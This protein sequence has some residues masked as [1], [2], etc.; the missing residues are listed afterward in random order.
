M[1]HDDF[2]GFCLSRHDPHGLR[3]GLFYIDIV[4]A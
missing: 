2:S 1:R 3:D 4:V